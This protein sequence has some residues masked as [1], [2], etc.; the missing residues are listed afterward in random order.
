MLKFEF[1]FERKKPGKQAFPKT[2]VT[3][4]EKSLY[5]N[6]QNGT[7]ISGKYVLDRLLLMKDKDKLLPP[8]TVSPQTE[9]PLHGPIVTTALSSL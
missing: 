6:P 9:T 1:D 7:A 2:L 4:F 8:R 5:F 3:I